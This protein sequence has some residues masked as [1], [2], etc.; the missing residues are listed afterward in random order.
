[1]RIYRTRAGLR[2][3]VTGADAPPLSDRARALL[4]ELRSDP[5][6]VELCATHDSYRARL[7]PKPHRMGALALPVSWPCVD[8][9][10]ERR[11]LRWVDEYDDLARGFST[12]RLISATGPVPSAD[13][14]RL[15]ELHDER[16]RTHV[17]DPLA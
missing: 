11:W 5:L 14:Q 12:C 3:L 1:M 16:T 6:Y 17:R 7:T 15:I 10:S 2:V 13:E 4:T 9:A 8:D